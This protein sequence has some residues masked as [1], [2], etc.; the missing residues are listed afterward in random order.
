MAEPPKQSRPVVIEAN[1]LPPLPGDN[2]EADPFA[3]EGRAMQAV[4]ARAGAG[5]ARR[6]SWFKRMFWAAA[7]A[8]LTLVISLAAYESLA[9]LISSY[10]LLGAIASGLGAIVALGLLVVVMRE[11]AGIA[12]LRRIDGL[13]RRVDAAARGNTRAQALEAVQVLGAFYA[14]REDLRWAW[15][16]VEKRLPDALDA[17]ALLA[18]AERGLMEPLDSA[19][20]IEVELAARQVAAATAIIPLPLVDVLAALAVNLKM[21]RRVAAIYGGRTGTLGSWR[22]LRAVGAHLL[23]TGAVAMGDDLLGSVVGGGAI[24]KVSRRLGEGVVNGALTARVG[25]AAMDVCRPMPF[26]ALKRPRVTS[27]VKRAL[28]GLFS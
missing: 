4:G 24:G 16:D 13:R 1:A 15:R 12:R 20:R 23:A 11:A 3:P 25:I 5:P 18:L 7:A 10:P 6:G 28:T 2:A 14:A 9:A 17:P 8:L 22:L 19:A 26:A 21:L 27:L